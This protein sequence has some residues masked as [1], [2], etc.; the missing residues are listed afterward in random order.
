MV[1]EVLGSSGKGY[2]VSLRCSIRDRSRSSLHVLAGQKS[3]ESTFVNEP[4]VHNK[5][6]REI[7]AFFDDRCHLC[8]AEVALLRRWDRRKR[9]DFIDISSPNFKAEKYGKSLDELMGHMHAR[10][11]DGTWVVGV[12]VFR[13]LYQIVGLGL[14]VAVSRWPLIS[15]LLTF[16][17]SIFAKVRLKL[18]R[19]KCADDICRI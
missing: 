18:P 16:G 11:P 9:I 10:L 14:P 5:E 1:A 19:R 3:M 17:Y 12:E 7:E 8:H 15:G 13:R 6:S 4:V 2:R